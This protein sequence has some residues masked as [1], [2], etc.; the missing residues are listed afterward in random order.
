MYQCKRL[1]LCV[2]CF[3]VISLWVSRCYAS[4]WWLYDPVV[5]WGYGNDDIPLTDFS[6]LPKTNSDDIDGWQEQVVISDLD[7]SGRDLRNARIHL[8]GGTLKNCKFDHANLGGADFSETTLINCSFRGANLRYAYLGPGFDCDMTD[9]T[10]GGVAYNLTAAQ[11]Q[12]TW[13][14]K[15]KDFSNTNFQNCSFPDVEYDSS[16]NFTNSVVGDHKTLRKNIKLEDFGWEQLPKNL[17]QSV[18]FRKNRLEALS[19]YLRDHPDYL[20]NH[21]PVLGELAF[22]AHDF[23]KKSLHG[24]TITEIDFSNCDFSGFTLGFF[25]RC[26]F[27]NANFKDAVKLT[28]SSNNYVMNSPDAFTKIKFGFR[29]CDVT[30]EQIEQTRFW[31]EGN[32]R[33]IILEDMNLDGWDFSHKDLSYASL[34]GSSVRGANFE[35]AYLYYTN[36]CVAGMTAADGLLASERT[37][38]QKR[39]NPQTYTSTLTV[40]QL[41]QT[42]SWKG[43]GITYCQFN[44]VNFDDCDLSGFDFNGTS[45]IG[46]SFNNANLAGAEITYQLGYFILCRGLT[47]KQIRS[48]KGFKEEWLLPKE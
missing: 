28:S 39:W 25:E 46:C 36:L 7:L 14:F 6:K 19:V 15:N 17:F 35:N 48:L 45:I 47:E 5:F 1:L 31:K 20:E 29:N 9:A 18:T 40:A 34:K 37:D 32:L 8:F 26:T 3:A 13:N 10:L 23:L 24:L 16:F 38:E 22:R 27:E 42:G 4:Q 33:G 41:K 44:N 21:F 11:M 30:K 43:K 12:S 2:L